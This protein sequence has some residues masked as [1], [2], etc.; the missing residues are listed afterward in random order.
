M[1]ENRTVYSRITAN[2][3]ENRG[4][5]KQIE[6]EQM[7]RSV[8]TNRSVFSDSKKPI[9]RRFELKPQYFACR[10][11]AC[12]AC[13]LYRETISGRV[14]VTTLSFVFRPASTHILQ[15]LVE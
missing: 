5:Q 6:K 10:W 12:T 3:A 8:K 13:I 2:N 4:K 15:Q 9:V 14:Q 7:N 11:S 1:Y